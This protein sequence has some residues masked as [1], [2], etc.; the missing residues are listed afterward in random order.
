MNYCTYDWNY[1]FNG[2][3]ND[4]TF[5]LSDF[6]YFSVCKLF[7]DYPLTNISLFLTIKSFFTT[8]L[9]WMTD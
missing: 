7:L 9:C 5:I 8:Q 4:S 6:L 1:E 2:I 3:E